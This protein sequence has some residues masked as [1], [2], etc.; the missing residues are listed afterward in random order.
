MTIGE[1]IRQSRKSKGMRGEDLGLAVGLT[2][3]TISKIEKDG[4]KGGPDPETLVRISEALEDKSILI[5]ALLNNPICQRIIPR[6]F[7]PLNNINENTS[8]IL[9]KLREELNEAVEAVDILARIFSVK[10]PT[11]TP[12]YKETLLAKLE[13]IIDAPRCIEELFAHLKEC[14]AMSEEEHLEVHIRQQ[15][16]VEAHGHHKPCQKVA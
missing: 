3:S 16:K 7:A 1:K 12:A 15:A 6:A 13:Q 5:Y 2:K 8:A 9:A 14:G 11:T 10:D 4:I